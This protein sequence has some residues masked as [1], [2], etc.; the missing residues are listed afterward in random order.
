MDIE[1]KGGTCLVI[2]VKKC[3]IVVDPTLHDI[4]LKDQGANADVLLFTQQDQAKPPHKDDALMID[5]PGEYEVQNISIKGIPALPYRS[6]QPA[7]TIYWLGHNGASLVVA[8]HVNPD[9]SEDQLEQISFADVLAIPVGGNGYTLDAAQAV[10]LVRKIDPKAVIP[11]HYADADAHYPVVQNSL[12]A[13]LK[14]L[15][16]AHNTVTKLKLKT[17]SLTEALSVQEIK[18][19][20]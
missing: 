3:V 16:A 20:T 15:S 10:Q 8:G 17:D 2:S 13:F 5:G 6:D 4:G 1:F 18:R 14:E 12:E 7:S 19:T 11:L 9:L